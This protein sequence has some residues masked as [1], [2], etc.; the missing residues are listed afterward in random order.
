MESLAHAI[1]CVEQQVR[2]T[3]PVFSQLCFWAEWPS[4]AGSN[5]S[6]REP[7][8]DWHGRVWLYTYGDRAELTP[9]TLKDL[10]PECRR[11]AAQYV[12]AARPRIALAVLQGWHSPLDKDQQTVIW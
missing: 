1:Q 11:R 9:Y 3:R 4:K 10:E 6:L 7:L 2:R 8:V 5:E 12:K